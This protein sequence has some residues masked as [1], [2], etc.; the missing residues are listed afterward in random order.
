M[1]VDDEFRRRYPTTANRELAARYG[2]S[3]VTILKWAR[4]LGLRK[5]TD[6]RRGVQAANARQRR[7]SAEQRAR[8]SSRARGRRMT[9][10]A[11]A[12]AMRTKRE[13]GSILRGAAH[14]SWKGGRPW[15]RFNDP[16]YLRWRRSVLERDAYRCQRCGRECRKRERGLAAHHIKAYAA[17]P[18]LRL[19]VA[20]GMT[21]CRE[22]HMSLH[23]RPVKERELLACACGCGTP[24][25]PVDR[26][27]RPRRF[28]NHHAAR[29]RGRT[30]TRAS[31]PP[32]S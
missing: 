26:Y 2:R 21:L 20:N 9:P 7:L 19:D 24:I 6:Y 5:D 27:G 16:E 15:V 18:A 25:E 4:R 30:S 28:V 22:C 17:Y 12:K 10:E 31:G 23:G 1:D 32:S 13:R 3:T 29:V 14:P 11:I 8:L